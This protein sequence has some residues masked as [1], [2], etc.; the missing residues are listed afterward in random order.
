VGVWV[1]AGPGAAQQLV[2]TN[3]GYAVLL[4]KGKEPLTAGLMDV[5]GKVGARL[6]QPQQQHWG[7][8]V[9]LSAALT[10]A[11]QLQP[12]TVCGCLFGCPHPLLLLLN[13]CAGAGCAGPGRHGCR[14][15]G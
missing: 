14:A 6:L 3:K 7:S 8:L 10:L 13:V 12:G 5:Y 15:Q 1:C 11:T 9:M 4:K 2:D